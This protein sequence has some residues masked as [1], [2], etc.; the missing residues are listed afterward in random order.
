[1]IILLCRGPI[2]KID[3]VNPTSANLTISKDKQTVIWII[4][5]KFPQK[6][7]EMSLGASVSFVEFPPED[8]PSSY[9]TRGMID[10][11]FCVEQNAFCEVS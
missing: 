1:M 11:Q 3:N 5:Q 2:E 8:M 4:G 7:L 6:N 10:E 9:D